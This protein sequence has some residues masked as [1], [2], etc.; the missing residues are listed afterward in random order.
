MSPQKVIDFANNYCHLSVS[1]DCL[2]KELLDLLMTKVTHILPNTRHIFPDKLVEMMKQLAIADVYKTPLHEYLS[3]N[4]QI[5]NVDIEQ[6]TALKLYNVQEY[7][8][9]GNK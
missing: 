4:T 2:D 5:L 7:F 3:T 9:L 1:L 6:K 8:R